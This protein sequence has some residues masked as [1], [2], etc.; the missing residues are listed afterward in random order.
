[1]KRTENTKDAA[2]ARSKYLRSEIL[3]YE[4]YT[5]LGRWSPLLKNRGQ[6]EGYQRRNK[7]NE[8]KRKRNECRKTMIG[9]K[10]RE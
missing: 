3:A 5:N 2:V 1:L 10:R 9:N 7:G 4:S 6:Q 8:D